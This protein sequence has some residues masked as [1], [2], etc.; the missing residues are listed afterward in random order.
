MKGVLRG[1]LITGAVV[2]LLVL[3]CAAYIYHPHFPGTSPSSIVILV[4][5]PAS[6]EIAYETNL[7]NASGCKM[8][9][10]GLRHAVFSGFGA[11]ADGELN[12]RYENGK[13]DRVGFTRSYYGRCSFFRGGFYSMPS[14]DFFE[15]LA[16]G[17]MDT[18]ILKTNWNETR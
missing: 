16:A 8:V 17:G 9:V 2:C 10:A 15:V 6:S 12:I 14:N 13:T 1:C 7:T 18:S 5:R 4:Y 3:S 11:K